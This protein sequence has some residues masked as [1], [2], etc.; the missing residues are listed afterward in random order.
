MLVLGD[1]TNGGIESDSILNGRCVAY[2]PDVATGPRGACCH[3]NN[4]LHQLQTHSYNL[5]SSKQLEVYT[6]QMFIK[7][8]FICI[9]K[10]KL[11]LQAREIHKSNPDKYTDEYTVYRENQQLEHFS[12]VT[13]EMGTIKNYGSTS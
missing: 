12:S 6:L 9:L 10:T 2:V 3:N 1:V 8:A 13:S 11:T 5:R 7:E 4:L